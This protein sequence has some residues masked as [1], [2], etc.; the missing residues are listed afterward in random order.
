MAQTGGNMA[1]P[2]QLRKRFFL[3][4]CCNQQS[5]F[6]FRLCAVIAEILLRQECSEKGNGVD[7]S[8]F[9]FAQSSGGAFFIGF[10]VDHETC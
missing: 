8:D 1:R 6:F 5:R 9:D 2:V 3:R 10:K 4:V 7:L